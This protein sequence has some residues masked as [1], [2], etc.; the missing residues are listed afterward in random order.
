MGDGWCVVRGALRFVGFGM[1]VLMLERCV[2][3]VMIELAEGGPGLGIGRAKERTTLGRESCVEYVSP[4][5]DSGCDWNL[6]AVL[7]C[8]CVRASAKSC[9]LL[10]TEVRRSSRMYE[11]SKQ[12]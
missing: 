10:S 7:I 4:W 12:R 1:V 2:V 8:V 6:T 9:P 3:Y 5:L 11:K